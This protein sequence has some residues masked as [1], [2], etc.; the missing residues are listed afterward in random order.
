MKKIALFLT[1]F[2]FIHTSFAQVV[3]VEKKRKDDKGFSGSIDLTLNIQETETRILELENNINLQYAKKSHKL[4]FL[5][6]IKMLSVDTGSL[7]NDGYQHLRY[8]Y[9]IKDSS[10]LT[11]EAFAQHQ[12]NEQKDFNKRILF[13]GG[14]RFRAIN[15]DKIKMFIAP[16]VMYEFIEYS[17]DLNSEVNTIRLDSYISFSLTLSKLISFNHITY[18]QP[19]FSDFSNY[20]ISSVTGLA[21]NISKYLSYEVNYGIDYDNKP[22]TNVQK[23]FW[24]F[25]NA[26]VLNF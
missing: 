12:Y 25:E 20:R 6:N 5:N 21:F 13:G 15:K 24:V 3:N 9:T 2:V 26:L 11:L 8:N 19:V 18:Y 10:F 16:L 1:L 22:Y 23:T 17:D 4:I 7:V 14:P